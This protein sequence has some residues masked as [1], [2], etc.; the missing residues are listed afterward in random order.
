LFTSFFRIANVARRSNSNLATSIIVGKQA[1]CNSTP[2]HGFH[3]PKGKRRPEA[4]F[5]LRVATD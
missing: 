1:D 3:E 4:A 2:F 5:F